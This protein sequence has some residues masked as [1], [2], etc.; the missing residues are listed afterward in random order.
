MSY[1][2]YGQAPNAEAG[3]GYGQQVSHELEPYGQPYNSQ[4]YSQQPHGTPQQS[5]QYGSPQ[6]QSYN[7]QSAN[8]LPTA[9]FLSRVSGIREDMRELSKRVDDIVQLHQ[10]ALTSS[11]GSAREQLDALVAHTQ[12]K[13]TAIRDQIQTL[14]GDA[15]RTSDGSFGLKKRQFESLNKEYKDE[16]QKYLREEQEYRERYREQIARQ[17]RIVNPS[18]TE[19]EVQ[20][21][22]DADWGNEGVF[23]TALKSNRSGHASEVLRN[24]QARHTEL[25]NIER[26]IRDLMDLMQY[27]STQVVEQS[28]MVQQAA[29]KAE[30]TTDHLDNA[31]V[32][33]GKGVDHAR[34][35]RRLKWW[36]ALVVFLIVLAIALGVG[37]GIALTN[38][39]KN[40]T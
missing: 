24:V 13:N 40:K 37:L 38:Q 39:N 28:A 3:Y 7:M 18:A 10:R 17:Y 30:E 31:N 1:N 27:L 5:H 29:Q 16:I 26:Q 6:Q 2:P 19:A 12:I 32:Q 4:P 22:Q 11:D 14:K 20:Q 21:A 33:L 36:C 9:D 8:V 23:Q 25:L 15:E 35:R 34:R